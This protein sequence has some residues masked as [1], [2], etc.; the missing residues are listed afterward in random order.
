VEASDL[1]ASDLT[2]LDEV[3]SDAGADEDLLPFPPGDGVEDF[4]A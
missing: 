2:P 1:E 4:L 3:V